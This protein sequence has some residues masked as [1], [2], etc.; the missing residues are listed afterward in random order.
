MRLG[1]RQ[2]YKL[3]PLRRSIQEHAR[4]LMT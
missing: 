1:M 3:S 4:E 2:V